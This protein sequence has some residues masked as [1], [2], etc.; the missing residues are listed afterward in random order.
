MTIEEIKRYIFENNKIGF[1]LESLGC[2]N[3]QFD[4]R[5]NCFSAAFPDGDN[6]KGVIISNN[7]FL[8]YKSF[9]RG[10]TFTDTKDIIELIQYI[11]GKDFIDA[12]KYLHNIL[13]LE[14][15]FTKV[16]KKKEE[17]DPLAIFKK[18]LN[19][20]KQ[21]DAYDINI[22][23]ES[24]LEDYAPMLHIDWLRDGITEKTRKK[25]GI[26]YSY[27]HKRVIIPL[28]HWLTG[29]LMGVNGRTTIK[30]YDELGIKKYY[31]S[32]S[33]QK[34]INLYGLHE[35]Y[36][37]IKKAGYVVV[38]EAERSVLKRD[39]LGDSTGVAISGHTLSEEQAR[40]LIGLNVDIVIALDK[41][42]PIEEVRS[43][44]EKF[45]HIRNVSYIY[46]DLNLIGEKDSPAD[47]N[48]KKFN[49][50]FKY[51]TIYDENE[52]DALTK[53]LVRGGV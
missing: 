21:V 29:E 53:A 40:I 13:G 42:V 47:A 46:D 7:T 23:D 33:Y 35:N 12:I 52:H 37:A 49:M 24:V 41:D 50:L 1:V 26:V 39:S 43:I 51:R 19:S 6:P 17:F 45:Y 30:N 25:F 8:G 15:G 32:P 14:F 10:V 22:M 44:C 27:K 5:G 34:S 48:N 36:E 2:H 4:D 38:Y 18:V 31:I 9:T 11:T 28:R 20:K 3:V 16:E